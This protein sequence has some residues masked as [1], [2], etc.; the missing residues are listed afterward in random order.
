MKDDP[1]YV[2]LP[3]IAVSAVL[4]VLSSGQA[5]KAFMHQTADIQGQQPTVVL[6][7]TFKDQK[8]AIIIMSVKTILLD[9]KLKSCTLP[10]F[11]NGVI[12]S[13]KKR[14][15]TQMDLLSSKN[16]R[17]IFANSNSVLTIS[18]AQEEDKDMGN[19]C[20]NFETIIR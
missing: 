16:N 8:K 3:D 11:I 2:F 13:L 18:F 9:F 4:W 7:L 6:L 12:E 17:S 10:S 5:K 19:V 20:I 15:I 1:D 14:S